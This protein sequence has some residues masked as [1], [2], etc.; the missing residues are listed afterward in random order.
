M[1]PNRMYTYLQYPYD[2]EYEGQ[3]TYTP[4]QPEIYQMG[5]PPLNYS[6]YRQ[7][8]YP[9]QQ[10]ELYHSYIDPT[11]LFF[12]IKVVYPETIKQ[13]SMFI[14]Q[15]SG[16]TESL[17]AED[18]FYV[19]VTF[20]S[21]SMA[22]AAFSALQNSIINNETIILNPVDSSDLTATKYET[23]QL[24]VFQSLSKQP[25]TPNEDPPVLYGEFNPLEPLGKQI[26]NY[27]Y[28]SYPSPSPIS[29]EKS[30]LSYVQPDPYIYNPN[31]PITPVDKKNES[32]T[33]S[34]SASGRIRASHGD[35][36]KMIYTIDVEKIRERS[37]KR[38]TL[39][40]K[41]I[42]NKYTQTMVLTEIDVNHKKKYDFFYLPIDFKNKCNVGY[43][44]INFIDSIDILNFY[45]EFSDRKWN[46]FNSEKICEVRYGR[47][48]GKASLINHF[49]NSSVMA[50]DAQYRP[51]LFFSDGDQKGEPEQFPEQ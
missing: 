21:S 37:D 8:L 6:E 17:E 1:E 7:S 39:M 47:I 15:Y 27:F 3:P 36:D 48:Q 46:K 5:L 9:P 14:A 26:P 35:P 31:K 50:V 16:M 23:N 19:N 29:D 18:G 10:P 4:S 45:R 33:G 38:T 40:I 12:C 41:N 25:M 32:I 30:P 11:P 51:L 49:R 28:N 34:I 22:T 13:L 44:F 24:P 42:P 43:A 20:L 2:S